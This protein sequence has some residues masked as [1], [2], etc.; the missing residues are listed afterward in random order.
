[1]EQ[2][3]KP[4]EDRLIGVLSRHKIQFID[5]DGDANPDNIVQFINKC[6]DD[7]YQ[8][9][10]LTKTTKNILIQLCD[11]F[12]TYLVKQKANE[13]A[14]YT[15][16]MY[17]KLCNK[18]HLCNA[19]TCRSIQRNRLRQSKTN[20][21]P[22]PEDVYH[23]SIDTMHIKLYHAIE[24][25]D[26]FLQSATKPNKF[27]TEMGTNN[28]LMRD[29]LIVH[30]RTRG[31]MDT[32]AI[33]D[34]Y[35]ALI[36][37]EYDTDCIEYDAAIALKSDSAE[38]NLYSILMQSNKTHFNIV[39]RYLFES[40]V[41]T[42][43]YGHGIR[44]Y[45]WPFYKDTKEDTGKPVIYTNMNNTQQHYWT[46]PGNAGYKTRDWY[47][48]A[49]YEDMRDEIVNNPICSLT[50]QQYDSLQCT[51]EIEFGKQFCRR[52][53]QNKYLAA[54][55]E[56]NEMELKHVVAMLLYTN[57]TDLCTA[58]ARTLRRA[59]GM[60][61]DEKWK[62]RHANYWHMAKTLRE[63]VE[64]FGMDRFDMCDAYSKLYH[65]ISAPL[66]LK[67]MYTT[68]CGTMST[69]MNLSVASRFATDE[70]VVLT[71]FTPQTRFLL[72]G[73]ECFLISAYPHEEEIL[74]FG[75]F[76][77]VQIGCI[78]KCVNGTWTNYE[79]HCAVIQGLDRMTSGNANT[80]EFKS[81][82]RRVLKRMMSWQTDSNID[83]NVDYY[84]RGLFANFC[85]HRQ[86]LQVNWRFM[87]RDLIYEDVL[88]K[89]KTWGYKSI[90]KLFVHPRLSILDFG[91]IQTMFPSLQ[92]IV[93]EKWFEIIT[94]KKEKKDKENEDEKDKEEEKKEVEKEDKKEAMPGGKTMNDLLQMIYDSFKSGAASKL[95]KVI[96]AFPFPMKKS[97]KRCRNSH[98]LKPGSTDITQ[99]DGSIMKHICDRCFER[100]GEK[101]V[102]PFYGCGWFLR[103]CDTECDYSVCTSCYNQQNDFFIDLQD[104][105]ND[106]YQELFNQISWKITKGE[107]CNTK[108]DTFDAIVFE[109]VTQKEEEKAAKVELVDPQ[110]T[111]E[112]VDEEPIEE[113]MSGEDKLHAFLRGIS[114][115]FDTK[116]SQ[117]LIDAGCDTLDTLKEHGGD[118][119]TLVE[120]GIPRTDSEEIVQALQNEDGNDDL[121]EEVEE[122]QEEVNDPPQEEAKEEV[123]EPNDLMDAV[124]EEVNDAPKEEPKEAVNDA[125]KEEPQEELKE[126]VEESQKEPKEAVTDGAA[127]EEPHP[128]GLVLVD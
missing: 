120:V 98:R 75:G 30:L 104:A 33:I 41:H 107:H 50:K 10:E 80:K 96:I 23:H 52:L 54:P 6:G 7:F 118:V 15:E 38:C 16:Q 58:F 122:A 43:V 48:E 121:K 39:T 63:M 36:E 37:K 25:E 71:L 67:S 124:Q 103:G 74:F 113:C 93:I 12:D 76:S 119:E 27:V 47:V 24:M 46:D 8:L 61:T 83:P 9:D 89:A 116:H 11:D 55:Y 13:T 64:V 95:R 51:A 57:Y 20:T 53:T 79:E 126:E 94:Y 3:D 45:Y 17:H 35:E 62:A 105:I 99:S 60:E 5:A 42:K 114:I 92:E 18:S 91:L 65:G 21:D 40:D 22:K 123:E 29:G 117:T 85:Q 26:H 44:F 109:K 87:C 111:E 78:R 72:F 68:F 19:T 82:F 77:M 49:K 84:V 34:F 100:M 73:F 4:F 2:D 112:E 102:E 81:K 31:A 70:G 125:P 97:N 110:E 115:D 108:R 90:R 127:K 1:M 101:K 14:N 56:V 88:T 28:T 86:Y 128:D 59:G 32:Q 66:Y 106:K 69:S